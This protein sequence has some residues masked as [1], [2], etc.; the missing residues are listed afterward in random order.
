MAI[1]HGSK[2]VVW[3]NGQDVSGYFDDADIPVS[4]DTAE[5]TT[6]GK[7]AKTYVVGQSDATFSLA[8]KY[9]GSAA[10]IDEILSGILGL[11]DQN[12]LWLPGGDGFGNRGKALQGSVSKYDVHAPV[13]GVVATAL[14]VQADGGVQAT[15]V[16]HPHATEAAA[17]NGSA[18]DNG[19]SSANGGVGFLHV[20]AITGTPN[21]VIKIQHSTDNITFTDLI[22]FANV[23]AAKTAQKVAVAGTVNRYVRAMVFSIGGASSVSF[24][25][26]FARL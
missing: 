15:R 20:D 12:L 8:G 19:A 9:D 3:L 4:V 18:Y 24:I 16:L 13:N 1:P 22:T 14:D 7:S 23:T 25:V 5:S 6:F 10:A 21:A 2:A 26:A 11:G 17:M